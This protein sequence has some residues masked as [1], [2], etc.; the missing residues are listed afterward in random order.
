M[1]C[2]PIALRPTACSANGP[3]LLT[4][5]GGR[6]VF[7]GLRAASTARQSRR[8]RENGRGHWQIGIADN[9]GRT[10]FSPTDGLTSSGTLVTRG[11]DAGGSRR[12]HGRH[13]RKSLGMARA[14]PAP[15]ACSI[16]ADLQGLGAGPSSAVGRMRVRS[17]SR[18]RGEIQTYCLSMGRRRAHLIGTMS[19]NPPRM[20]AKQP[21]CPI[22]AVR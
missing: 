16:S 7:I 1:F 6:P 17:S 11:R 12:H 2:D 14:S 3:M 13:R 15:K 21:P 8:I 10:L 22:A 4:R 19:P 20:A 5:Q 9:S 18:S